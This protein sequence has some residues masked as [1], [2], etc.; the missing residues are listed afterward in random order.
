MSLTEYVLNDGDDYVT[1]KV[2]TDAQTAEVY[3]HLPYRVF[4]VTT[5]GGTITNDGEDT[6]AVTISVVDGLEI[7]RGTD[8]QN[9]TVLDV[10]DDVSLTVNGADITKSLENGTM[11]FDVTT[12]KTAG[13]MVDITAVSL[14]N[15]PAG[16]DTAEIE[17]TN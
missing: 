9:A 10:S 2:T 7:A 12:T 14:V 11:S 5:D 6:V 1:E 13:G 8:R 15:H 3:G 4:H 16:R 17:V